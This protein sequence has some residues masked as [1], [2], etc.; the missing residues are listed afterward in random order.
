MTG[1]K[2]TVRVE[3]D[4]IPEGFVQWQLQATTTQ[5]VPPSGFDKAVSVMLDESS[6]RVLKL[7]RHACNTEDAK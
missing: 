4:R 2:V 6:D 7:I 5:T 3:D 1:T